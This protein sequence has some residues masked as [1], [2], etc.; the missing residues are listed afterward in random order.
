MKIPV[1]FRKMLD[2][3][4]GAN[5]WTVF[6]SFIF[7]V[8]FYTVLTVIAMVFMRKLIIGVSRKIEFRLRNNIYDKLLSLNH[9]FFLK[10]ET[11]DLVS[12]C[13]NDLDNVRTL[14]GPGI[15]YIPNAVSRFLIFFPVLFKLNFKLLWII[16]FMQGSLVVLIILILPKIRPMYQK[17]QE[18]LG[19]INNQVWQVLSG[20]TTIKLY[21]RE[22]TEIKRFEKLNREY[23][24][25]EMAL[26]KRTGFLWPFFLLVIS[27]TE[28]VILLVGGKEIIAQRMSMGELLQ[29]TV[30]MSYLTFPVLSL[31]WI[32]SLMQQ[33][34][35]AMK[36][37]DYI[38]SQPDAGVD[39]LKVLKGKDIEIKI[40]RLGFRYPG[41]SREVLKDIS[42]KIRPGQVVGIAGPVGSGKTTLLNLIGGILQPDRGMLFLNHFAVAD[43]N[44]VS[45]MR[46]V[47]MVPQKTFL[48]SRSIEE[49]ILMAAVK[50]SE[51]IRAVTR[52]AGLESDLN[53]FP[54]GLNQIVGER[55]ITLSGGQKQRIAI[56]RALMKKSPLLIFDD[57]L[58]S[59]DS[60][61][62]FNILQDI[63]GNRTFKTFIF[64]SHRIS[65]LRYAD[66]I[67]VLKDGCVIEKGNHLELIRKRKWYYG[68]AKFQQLEEEKP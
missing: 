45:I 22:K 64:T 7:P 55:G 66:V 49:N 60:R 25:R 50:N 21:T 58:S 59:V 16:T 12:R 3:V 31:G 15:M 4:M 20:I 44:P 11:G 43:L 35:S 14:L 53:S 39:R 61:T 68:M 47:S 24:S 19:F 37:I 56:A 26:V 8:A 33:G 13:T 42:L 48:F 28:L 32:M 27:V 10:N 18:F 1:Y 67:F 23:I 65:S 41:G 36:R 62:E 9:S 46:K 5:Q 51:K 38:L 40:N 34:I 57:A 52:S 63:I 29:F 30:M 2:E 54:E 6:R 17:I